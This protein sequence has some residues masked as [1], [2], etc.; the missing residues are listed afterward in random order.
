MEITVNKDIW[1][2]FRG[3]QINLMV[4]CHSLFERYGSV[5]SIAVGKAGILWL[6]SMV[7]ID[8]CD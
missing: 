8:Q 3:E 4:L 7:I 2:L 1:K 5:S 6:F